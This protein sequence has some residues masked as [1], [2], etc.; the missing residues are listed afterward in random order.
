MSA[1]DINRIPSIPASPQVQGINS[2]DDAAEERES[3]QEYQKEEEEE[4][5]L[6]RK[7]LE[8]HR[9]KKLNEKIALI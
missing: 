5:E 1:G 6:V 4:K 2:K 9:L 7:E 8:R 3:Q